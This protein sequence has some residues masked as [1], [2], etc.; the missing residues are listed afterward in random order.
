V[1]AAAVVLLAAPGAAYAQVQPVGEA[2]AAGT[3]A[4]LA[5]GELVEL[6]D[7]TV[8]GDIDLRPLGRVSA[9]LVCTRCVLRDGSASTA[10]RGSGE[11][12]AG[13]GVGRHQVAEAKRLTRPLAIS[14]PS[15]GRTFVV[16]GI[17]GRVPR[18]R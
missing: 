1:V 3:F 11:A 12:P 7:V 8:I 10:L 4:R 13:V 15:L 16:F 5:A 2:S 6:H 17:S 18:C 14:G 9:P